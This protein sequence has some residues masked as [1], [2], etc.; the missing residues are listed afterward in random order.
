MDVTLARPARDPRAGRDRA[1][2]LI[3]D[4]HAQHWAGKGVAE[5]PRP[6]RQQRRDPHDRETTEP[7]AVYVEGIL[8]VAP[9][10]KL[11]PDLHGTQN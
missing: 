6:H 5:G 2:L 3:R 8:N 7:E 10:L 9:G 1:A 4:C 11:P